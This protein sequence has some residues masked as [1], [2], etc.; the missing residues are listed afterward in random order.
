MILGLGVFSPV[1]PATGETEAGGLIEPEFQTS[2]DKI[3]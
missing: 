2:L 1:A 3:I